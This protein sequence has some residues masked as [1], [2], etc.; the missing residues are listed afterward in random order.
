MDYQ[1]L[2]DD[3]VAGAQPLRTAVAGLT[4]TQLDSK[5]IAGMWSIRQVVCHLADFEPIYA[6]RMKRVVAEVQPRFPGGDPDLFAAS[7]AYE[8]RRVENELEIIDLTR[9]Q[10]GR[11]LSQLDTKD[12]QRIGIHLEAGPLTLTQLLQNITGHIPHHLRFVEEKR[13]ALG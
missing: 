4:D 11:I 9:R 3:Y 10:M 5:P 8:N 2:I 6:D 7:L 13:K 12:F 1:R